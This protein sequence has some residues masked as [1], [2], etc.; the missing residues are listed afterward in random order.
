MLPEIA[1]ALSQ[2]GAGFSAISGAI[3]GPGNSPVDFITQE[4]LRRLFP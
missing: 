3:S 4:Y 1:P 2:T